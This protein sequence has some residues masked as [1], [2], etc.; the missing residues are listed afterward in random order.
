VGIGLGALGALRLGYPD[1]TL[2]LLAFLNVWITDSAAYF[3]GMRHGRTP[4]AP[5]ISPKKTWEGA[6]AGSLMATLICGV[7]ISLLVHTP[8]TVGAQTFWS[9][10][11][12]FPLALL[13]A[14]IISAAGQIGDLLESWL[15]RKAGVKDSGNVLPGHGG[16]LDRF[17]SLLL[18]SIILL[19]IMAGYLV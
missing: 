4:L 10:S 14:A 17:D 9:G 15:K 16:I 6:I 1:L 19:I 7:Y 5:S 13:Y 12:S 18:S 3:V 2:I 11:I 8:I